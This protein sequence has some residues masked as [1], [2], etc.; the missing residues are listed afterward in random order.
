MFENLSVLGVILAAAVVGIGTGVGNAIGLAMYKAFLE[1]KVE[2]FL[3]KKH[4]A[5]ALKKLKEKA[6]EV[7]KEIVPTIPDIPPIP[8][9]GI[10]GTMNTQ[11]NPVRPNQQP[12]YYKS[13]PKDVVNNI[14]GK[15][16]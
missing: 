9:K 12:I 14:L 13:Q 7:I 16:Y 5:E 2:R 6:P 1:E 11:Q 15:R 3:D 10:S 4:R 8:N